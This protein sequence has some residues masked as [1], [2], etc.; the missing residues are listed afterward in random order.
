MINK[1]KVPP[2]PLSWG[3]LLDPHA[4]QS[5]GTAGTFA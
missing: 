5:I 4:A 2:Y 1:M 3:R